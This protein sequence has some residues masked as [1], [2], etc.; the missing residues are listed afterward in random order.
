MSKYMEE[1]F[2]P[3]TEEDLAAGYNALAGGS[4]AT[5]IPITIVDQKGATFTDT[6]GRE[7]ID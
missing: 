6:E 5:G 3:Y 1:F 2:G 4:V 7:Y